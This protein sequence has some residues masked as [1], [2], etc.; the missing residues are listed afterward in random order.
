MR[1]LS[2]PPVSA[3]IVSAEGNLI[4][5]FVS[6]VWIILSAIDRSPAKVAVPPLTFIPD[7][8]V[9]NPTESIFVTSWYVNVPPIDT[10][11]PIVAIPDTFKFVSST[12]LEWRFD[13]PDLN[14]PVVMTPTTSI[15]LPIPSVCTF[16]NLLSAIYFFSYLLSQHSESNLFMLRTR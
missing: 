1:S 14:C 8:A 2:V 4:A 9:I 7:L 12:P 16:V 5:V 11:P 6:P 13:V 3:V 10:L 15:L